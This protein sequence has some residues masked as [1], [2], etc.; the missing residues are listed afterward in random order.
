MTRTTIRQ[1]DGKEM[2]EAKYPLTGYALHPSPPL[3][4]RDEW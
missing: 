4:D 1:I 3:P 2:L